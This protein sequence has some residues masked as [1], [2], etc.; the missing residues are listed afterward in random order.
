[1][2]SLSAKIPVIPPADLTRSAPHLPLAE[3][4]GLFF[5]A[6]SVRQEECEAQS[7]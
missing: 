7:E 6:F 1:M 5:L 4:K 2:Y 3:R